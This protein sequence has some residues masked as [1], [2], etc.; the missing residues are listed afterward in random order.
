[1]SR[2]VPPPRP[3]L[4]GRIFGSSDD[5]LREL[6]RWIEETLKGGFE[7][8]EVVRD[9]DGDIPVRYG[10]TLVFIRTEGGEPLSI[11]V[12]APLLVDFQMCPEVFEAANAINQKILRAK[13]VV[14]ADDAEIA[15]EADLFV[16]DGISSDDLLFTIE[17]V[18]ELADEYGPRLQERFGGRTVFDDEGGDEFDV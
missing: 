16:F 8:D 6:D 18:G 17:L 12:S 11:H 10:S 5:N 1:M 3:S 13:A 15:L 4:L 2:F 7:V 9:D 14:E